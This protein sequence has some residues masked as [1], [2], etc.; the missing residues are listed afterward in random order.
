LYL[1][2]L[3]RR[4]THTDLTNRMQK[5]AEKRNLVAHSVWTQMP[6][7]SEEKKEQIMR[8]K[9]TAKRKK[10]LTTQLVGYSAEDLWAAAKEIDEV[11]DGLENLV[12]AVF[13]AFAVFQDFDYGKKLPVEVELKVDEKTGH[14][15][16]WPKI[17]ERE[18]RLYENI[19]K[20]VE[21]IRLEM[22]EKKTTEAKRNLEKKY[23]KIT[24]N[25]NEPE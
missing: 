19:E 3:G 9:F 20:A 1:R 17:S 21:K 14:T 24:N 23:V 5:C 25:K 16:Y 2:I 6:L 7:F 12:E 11:N 4:L 10:G 15:C 18:K 22:D 13:P 8:M